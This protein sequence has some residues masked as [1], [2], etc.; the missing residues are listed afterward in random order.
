MNHVMES[1]ET[2]ELVIACLSILQ[3]IIVTNKLNQHQNI[4][5]MRLVTVSGYSC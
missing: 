4:F 2:Q 5:P 1:H 3:A